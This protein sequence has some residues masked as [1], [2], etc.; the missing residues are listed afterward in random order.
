VTPR[1]SGSVKVLLF[2]GEGGWSLGVELLGLRLDSDFD[3]K[4][5]HLKPRVSFIWKH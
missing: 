4:L 1:V 5:I 2:E 3:T